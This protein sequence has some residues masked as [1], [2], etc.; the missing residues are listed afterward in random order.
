MQQR[1]ST[2]PRALTHIATPFLRVQANDSE[3]NIRSHQEVPKLSIIAY[4]TTQGRKSTQHVQQQFERDF[5]EGDA[6]PGGSV[7]GGPGHNT[8]CLK[9]AREAVTTVS[10]HGFERGGSGGGAVLPAGEVSTF[11]GP[12]P[13]TF[14]DV[15][16]SL[17]FLG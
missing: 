4:I 10:G 7:T 16:A 5:C 11:E 14:P 3:H 2:L 1:F 12:F 13:F 8:A 6:G 17:D 15:P 9:R